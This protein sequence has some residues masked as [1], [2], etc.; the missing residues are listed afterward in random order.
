MAGKKYSLKLVEMR[1]TTHILQ[2]FF[3]DGS[4]KGRAFSDFPAAMNYILSG[5]A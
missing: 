3:Q 1:D 2:S 4:C 5:T